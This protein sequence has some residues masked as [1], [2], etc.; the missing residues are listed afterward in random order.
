MG[1]Y[2]QADRTAVELRSARNR[3]RAIRPRHHGAYDCDIQR[4]S[5]N[6][7]GY[8]DGS[9]MLARCEQHIT[10]RKK[11]NCQSSRRGEDLH[12]LVNRRVN[13]RSCLRLFQR[14]IDG[15]GMIRARQSFLYVSERLLRCYGCGRR[16][17]LVC[18]VAAHANAIP[19]VG[20]RRSNAVR[21][22]SSRFRHVRRT[23]LR[24]DRRISYSLGGCRHA[25][26][27][28]SQSSEFIKRVH[29]EFLR[30]GGATT[31]SS[32]RQSHDHQDL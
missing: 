9:L 25:Y 12:R 24:A 7:Q 21:D 10:T 2:I 14:V 31:I 22:R 19:G 27:Q 4:Y 5:S 15:G 13:T 6:D 3:S 1:E 11:Q 30:K 26:G 23:I 28:G 8:C 17:R 32:I 16:P 20:I 18:K 29:L